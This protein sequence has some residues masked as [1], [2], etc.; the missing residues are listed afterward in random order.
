[1]RPTA[2]LGLLGGMFLSAGCTDGEPVTDTTDEVDSGETGAS[3]PLEG[4]DGMDVI[5]VHADTLRRDHLPTYGYERV[6]TPNLLQQP[7]VV[8]DG[9]QASSSWTLPSTATALLSLSPEHHG[10]VTVPEPEVDRERT[11]LAT[12]LSEAG[13]A[14]G[15]FSGNHMVATDP[16]MTVGFDEVL[17]EGELETVADETLHS[18]AA[19][20]VP[21]VESLP[22]GQ[23]YLLWLQPMDTHP[24]YRPQAPFRGTWADYDTLV[25]DP[26]STP[27]QQSDQFIQAWTAASSDEER[28]AMADN[29]RAVYDELILQED[30]A[31]GGL[32]AW[33]SYSGRAER[34]LVVVTADHGE[35]LADDLTPSISHG[36]TLRPE[37]IQ[38][39]LIFVHSRFSGEHLDCP[40]A[41]MDL[42]P[43]LLDA[44]GLPVPADLDGAPIQVGC[45]DVTGASLYGMDDAD[46]TLTYLSASDERYKLDWDCQATAA[47]IYDLEEDP[48]ALSPLGA[49]AMPDVLALTAS[50]E[51]TLHEARELDPDTLCDVYGGASNAP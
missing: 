34:T 21:W 14:T 12:R 32:F 36:I 42:G 15:L 16:V 29:V 9:Y 35:T 23:P 6:T 31:L 4:L 24:P 46:V 30:A 10:A 7:A 2:T 50:V 13:Y 44:L 5:V 8:I 3:D 22:E 49:E 11:T 19:R 20:A 26:E 45:R 41:N 33:L 47:Y 17:D 27:E 40:S 28:E 38:L 37:L 43:T 25:I 51:A 18:L 48:S 39:P 1:M